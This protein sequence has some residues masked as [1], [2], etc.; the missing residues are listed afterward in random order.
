MN[1]SDWSP[2]ILSL[3]VRLKHAGGYATDEDVIRDALGSLAEHREAVEGVRRGVADMEA[4][5]FLEAEEFDRMI[6]EKFS[7]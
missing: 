2:D 5:R 6:S 3:L 1:T 7:Q 4:G